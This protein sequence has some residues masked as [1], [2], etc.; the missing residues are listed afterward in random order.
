MHSELTRLFLEM[1][2]RNKTMKTADGVN[3]PENPPL[4]AAAALMP[5]FFLFF[6]F[7]FFPA[8]G[9]TTCGYTRFLYRCGMRWKV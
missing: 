1:I 5:F 8:L 6:F 7:F 2:I 9:H 3:N 4:W